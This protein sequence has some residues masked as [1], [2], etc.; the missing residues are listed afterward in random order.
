MN[1][2]Q[3][4]LRPLMVGL[5]AVSLSSQAQALGLE[6]TSLL[7]GTEQAKPTPQTIDKQQARTDW[8]N[9]RYSKVQPQVGALVESDLI[10]P[11]GHH[12]FNGGFSGVRADGLNND[13]RIV[14]GDQIGRASCRERV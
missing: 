3:K 5:I 7:S 6:N 8:S 9:G 4:I 11:F 13:Y 12:L 1:T 2:I 10:Q 14:P